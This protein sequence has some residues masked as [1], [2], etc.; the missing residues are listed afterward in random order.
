MDS[1]CFV[2]AVLTHGNEAV[3]SLGG[4]PSATEVHLDLLFGID[5]K[6]ITVNYLTETFNDK[7]CPALKGKPRL[8]FLQ[9]TTE[10][11]KRT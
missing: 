6:A 8:F 5:G 9:V 10:H 1:D 11:S 7:Y 4:N 3:K 2:C